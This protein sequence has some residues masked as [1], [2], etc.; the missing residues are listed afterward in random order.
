[1]IDTLPKKVFVPDVS[2]VK[3]LG[4]GYFAAVRLDDFSE[5]SLKATTIYSRKDFYKI[6]LISGN[7]TYYYRDSEYILSP[8]EWVLLDELIRD[9]PAMAQTRKSL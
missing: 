2:K 4:A 5:E 3:D 6:S 7:A 1:M 9:S 8:G